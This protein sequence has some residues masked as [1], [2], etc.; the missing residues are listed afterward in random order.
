MD[1]L[2]GSPKLVAGIDVGSLYT[3]TVIMDGD[4]E[5]VSFSLVRSGA[6]YKGAA[7]ASLNEALKQAG[8]QSRDISYIVSTGY[9]RALVSFANSE[10]TEITCHARGVSKLFPQ[11]R[12]IIDICGQDSKIMYV[13]NIPV[14]ICQG[15]FFC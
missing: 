4:G 15:S 14:I 10:V 8:A 12:T 9:G 5:V 6:A 13:K 2:G 1:P 3:K 7:E 11:A